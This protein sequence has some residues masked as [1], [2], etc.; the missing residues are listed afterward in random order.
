[1]S[2]E[3]FGPVLTV[4]VCPDEEFDKMVEGIDGTG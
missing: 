2:E 1:M 3:I 4:Y